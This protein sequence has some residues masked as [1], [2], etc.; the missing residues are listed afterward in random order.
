MATKQRS[1]LDLPASLRAN[2]DLRNAEEIGL[3]QA[4]LDE[5]RLALASG[6]VLPPKPT[7]ALDRANGLLGPDGGRKFA[8]WAF[9]GD[10]SP[11]TPQP[12]KTEETRLMVAEYLRAREADPARAEELA[13]AILDRIQG[14]SQ[15]VLLPAE[16]QAEWTRRNP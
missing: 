5:A 6:T 13:D 10:G 4:W 11:P 15:F 8:A 16:L 1:R 14:Q 12:L 9:E 7:N 3:V 2:C